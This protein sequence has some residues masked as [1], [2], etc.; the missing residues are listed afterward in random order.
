MNDLCFSSD[1]I[2]VA[3]IDG[4][5]EVDYL[6]LLPD[7]Y[8][9]LRFPEVLLGP[10]NV[11]DVLDWVVEEEIPSRRNTMVERAKSNPAQRP[12]LA[13]EFFV[14]TARDM[15]IDP[16]PPLVIVVDEFAEIMLSSKKLAQRFEQRV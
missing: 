5:G 13:R 9:P 7:E 11:L 15:N 8:F 10:G 6:G 12:R 14:E 2:K 4:K 1:A 16:Y 3:V